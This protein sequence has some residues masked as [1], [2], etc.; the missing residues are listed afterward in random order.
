MF[1]DVCE[2]SD[3][4][5]PKLTKH[6]RKFSVLEKPRSGPPTSGS[7]GRHVPAVIEEDPEVQAP[8]AP[9]APINRTRNRMRRQSSHM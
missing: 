6:Q 5:P 3:E 1:G 7:S 2:G 9:L 8:P 4:G